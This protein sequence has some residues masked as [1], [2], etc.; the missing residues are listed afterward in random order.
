MSGRFCNDSAGIRVAVGLAAVL[1]ATPEPC[2]AAPAWHV[3]AELGPE[4]DTNA[5]RVLK[6]RDP[7]VTS[8]L[9]R[10][11]ARGRVELR[12]G[13]RHLLLLEYGGGG[14]YFWLEDARPADELVQLAN[15]QWAVRL[16]GVML[17]LV[18]TYYDAFQRQSAR[19][20]RTGLGQ[21]RLE[22]TQRGLAPRALFHAGYRG[23][24]YK[25]DDG[26]LDRT[27][28]AGQF[29]AQAP[30]CDKYS[31][32]GPQGGLHLQWALTSGRGDALVDWSLELAYAAAYRAYAG[33]LRGQGER[34]PAGVGSICFYYADRRRQDLHQRLGAEV[35]YL[36]NAVAHFWYNVQFNTSNSFGATFVRHV[37]GIKFTADLVWEM[38]FTAKGVLQISNFRDP[39]YVTQ[40]NDQ[41]FV[42]FEEENR[43]SVLVQL[44]RG[45]GRNW[46]L[47]LRYAL[48]INESSSGGE[49]AAGAPY[50]PA[51]I[52]HTLL[53]GARLEYGSDV[54]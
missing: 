8:G 30:G 17:W 44:A 22:L 24:Q 35:A 16:P 5:T 25:P 42:D 36:G 33:L 12:P 2:A 50:I 46:S 51:Y 38:F 29:A 3:T 41:S 18:G 7:Q 31:F 52:R 34:C 37:I 39:Y 15:V 43:S 20:F 1:V 21:L 54:E 40:A 53:L 48:Y 28:C 47:H 32:H 26:D 27:Q 45:L 49:S 14:K 4:L 23:L 10:M 9:V 13:Q 11:T 6:D 19:D